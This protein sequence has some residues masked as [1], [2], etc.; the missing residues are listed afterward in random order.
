MGSYRP[1]TPTP[2]RTGR[3]LEDRLRESGGFQT[4]NLCL[5]MWNS[6]EGAKGSRRL[7]PGFGP[8]TDC[9]NVL[10]QA[11]SRTRPQFPYLQSG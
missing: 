1:H 3:F 9:L 5:K 10:G 4:S 2:E 7:A 11:M 6:I 8:T